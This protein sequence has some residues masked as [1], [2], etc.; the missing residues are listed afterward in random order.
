MKEITKE[1]LAE[2]LNGSEHRY[3]IAESQEE[4]AKR[5]NLLILFGESDDLLEARG[6]INDEFGAWEGGE[7][8]LMKEGE[9]YKELQN[10]NTYH[11]AKKICLVDEADAENAR[12]IKL[13]W[14]NARPEGVWKF[15]TKLA[16]SKFTVM[17]DG[18]PYGEGIIIDIDEIQ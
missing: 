14:I 13:E 12:R 10:D 4:V 8:L 11:K 1:Q 5:N 2:L 18:E 16:H 17:E 7:W 15:T 6:V 9:V 3:E